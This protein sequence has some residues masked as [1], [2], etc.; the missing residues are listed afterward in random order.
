MLKNIRRP[1]LTFWNIVAGFL[2]L[3]GLVAAIERFT[4]G[5]GATTHLSDHFPWGFWIGFDFIG[6]GLAAAGFTIA[7]TVHVFNVE[8]FEPIVRPSILTAY[9][10]YML[11]VLVLVVDLGRPQN[12]WHPLV[13]WNPHSVMFEITW[14]IILYTTV[15]TLEFAPVVLEKFHLHAPIRILRTIS[16]PIVVAGVILSTLHQS[17]FGSLYLVVPGRMHPLWFSDIIPFL[18][19][20]SCVAAGISM[21][22]FSSFLSARAF[23]REIDMPLFTELGRVLAVVLALFFTVRIQ[24]LLSRNALQFVF[25]PTYQSAMFLLE[26]TLG[27]LIPFFLLLFKRI[28][29]NRTGLFYTSALVIVGFVANRMNTAVTSMERWGERTYFPSWQE[30]AVTAG[31]A[32]AG[33]VA[34]YY[35]AKYFPVFTLKHDHAPANAAEREIAEELSLVAK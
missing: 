15:L 21:V 19:F 3:A 9:I 4:M 32:T 28:R 6:V 2:I 5:L 35:V 13:M 34:F 17:S 16:L 18:F 8:R 30:V 29:M 24:D 33:F 7:A 23:K 11:V 12:F 20:I 26:I 25:Q 31:L 14:C 1:H 10:G 27:V 22:I